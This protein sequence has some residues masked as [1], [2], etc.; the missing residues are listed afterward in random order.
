[1]NKLQIVLGNL[2]IS[3][4]GTIILIIPKDTCAIDTLALS[5]K[6]PIVS[7][8]NKY[9][10]NFSPVFNQPLSTCVDYTDTPFTTSSF[11]AFTQSNLGF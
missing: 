5:Q 3:K 10:A 9:L 11:I 1:M 7:I 6:I 4:N 2:Q 8:F